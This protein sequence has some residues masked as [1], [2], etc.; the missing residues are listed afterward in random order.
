MRVLIDECVPR[1]FKFT[2]TGQD[3]TCATVIEAGLGGKKNGELLRLAE[4]ALDVFITVDQGLEY[5][6]N[7]GRMKIAVVVI[8]SRSNRF[9]DLEPHAPAC[10]AVLRSIQ[11]GQLVKIGD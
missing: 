10:L 1:P 6:Q 4:T 9:A 7:L 3:H 5:Q 8:R 2:L 11:P